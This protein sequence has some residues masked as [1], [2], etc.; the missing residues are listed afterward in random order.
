MAKSIAVL[1]FSNVKGQK[2]RRSK[3]ISIYAANERTK[4][5]AT[6]DLCNKFNF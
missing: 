3:G 1:S 2:V 5:R 6:S 4:R